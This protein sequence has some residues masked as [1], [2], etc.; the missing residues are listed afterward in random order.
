MKVLFVTHAPKDPQ[1]AVFQV[2]REQA[3]VLKSRGHAVQILAPEDFPIARLIGR[4]FN[5][6]LFPVLVA[7]WLFQNGCDLDLIKFHSYSGWLVALFRPIVETWRKTR[8]V[9]E[10]HGLEPLYLDAMEQEMRRDGQRLTW[11]YRLINGWYMNAILRVACR[12]SDRVLCLNSREARFLLEQHWAKPGHLQTH[13]NAVPAKLLKIK[14]EYRSQSMSLLFVGQWMNMKGIRYLVEAFERLSREFPDL[15]LICAGT[16]VPEESVL[17]SFPSNLKSRVQVE[18]RVTRERLFE[19]H[20]SADIFVLPTLSEGSSL[21]LLE[22][23]AAECP[24][25]T[26]EAGAAPDLLVNE[27]SA[28]FVSAN[29]GAVAEAVR[30]LVLNLELRKSLGRNA[31]EAVRCYE[32]DLVLNHLADSLEQTVYSKSAGAAVVARTATAGVRR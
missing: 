9:T 29:G 23:M 27:T 12:R 25:V 3:E 10:F 30:R 2:I 26:T 7:A 8:I 28:L 5:P 31:R 11:R 15:Q 24:I 16:L 6:L 1:T 32:T 18:P 20:E 17:A 13:S 19:L 22:A 4:R 14:R 21:A